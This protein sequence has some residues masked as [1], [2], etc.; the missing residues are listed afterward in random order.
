MFAESVPVHCRLLLFEQSP[1]S[2]VFWQRMGQALSSVA[3]QSLTADGQCK[4]PSCAHQWKAPR[5]DGWTFM[6]CPAC[7]FRFTCTL[8]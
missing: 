2:R 8:K 5:G 1:C 3:P 6:T 7:R 4:C